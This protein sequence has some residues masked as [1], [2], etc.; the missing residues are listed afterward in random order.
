[1]HPFKTITSI[2]LLVSFTAAGAS[3]ETIARCGKGW[4]E[5]VDG[6]M[7][8]HL[9]GSHRE[10]GYQHGALLKEHCAKNINYLVREKGK[11]RNLDA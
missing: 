10:M 8:L 6:Q 2:F 7:V 11:E 9:E 1:M 3:A 5:K 4:L